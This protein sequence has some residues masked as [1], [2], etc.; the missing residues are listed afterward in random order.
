MVICRATTA[1]TRYFV[2]GSGPQSLVT[3]GCAFMIACRRVRCG[4][5]VYVQK[6]SSVDLVV[7]VMD[8]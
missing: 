1:T 4:S 2:N 5:S 7:T 6:K 3:A 8:G